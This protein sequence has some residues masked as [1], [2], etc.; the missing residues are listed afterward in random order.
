MR[1]NLFHHVKGWLVL[2]ST[3]LT[4]AVLFVPFNTTAIH[5]FIVSANVSTF[6]LWHVISDVILTNEYFLLKVS[7]EQHSKWVEMLH[8][9]K[10]P[11][12]R[13]NNH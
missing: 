11:S 10:D 7:P 12:V 3:V 6:L 2:V 13:E 4:L 1:P 5:A 9:P 8:N